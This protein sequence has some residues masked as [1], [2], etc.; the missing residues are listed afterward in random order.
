MEIEKT[1]N[2]VSDNPIQKLPFFSLR[3][4]MIL[5]FGLLFFVSFASFELLTLFGIPF[6]KYEGE[7]ER[8][9]SDVFR[10]LNLVADLKKELIEKW[11]KERIQDSA[12]F[13]ERMTIR[14]AVTELLDKIGEFQA[15]G[16]KGRELWARARQEDIY[17]SL[18]RELK[19]ISKHQF[20]YKKIEIADAGT[21]LVIASTSNA[22]L[23][24]DIFRKYSFSEK[25]A[26]VDAFAINTEK[27][28][29]SGE[30]HLLVSH[31]I[32]DLKTYNDHDDKVVAILVM[33]VDTEGIIKPILYAGGGLGKTGEALLVDQEAR[34]LTSLKHNLSDG[35]KAVPLEYR[36]KAKPSLM[37]AN[38]E[39]GITR[40]KD[41]RGVPVLAAYRYIPITSELGWGMVVKRDR[42]EVFAPITQK[43]FF[44]ILSGLICVFITIVLA[45]WVSSNLANPIHILSRKAEQVASGDFSVRAEGGSYKEVHILVSTF[46]S[47][48]KRIGDW[49][50]ELDEEVKNRT[51]ELK[52]TNKKLTNA[53]EVQKLGE[54]EL[55]RVNIVLQDK[56]KELEQIIY[57]AS[58]DLRSPLVNIHGFTKEIAKTLDDVN[59]IISHEDVSPS[60]QKK[61]RPFLEEDIPEAFDFITAGTSK[62]D[63]LISGLLEVSRLGRVSMDIAP[64]DMNKLIKTIEKS[65]EYQVRKV[66]AILEIEELPPCR[67]HETQ[68]NQVFSNLLDNALKYRIPKRKPIIKISGKRETGQAV[69]CVEDNGIGISGDYQGKIF[70]M[71]H[72]LN[73]YDFVGEGLGLA[74]VSKIVIRHEGKV[75]V[76]SAQDKGS[77]FFISLPV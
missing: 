26:L 11:I 38:G 24:K 17:K 56:N 43:V 42:E 60:L 18:I 32:M 62:M 29:K 63:A 54:K 69:Y 34:I 7:L 12:I 57:V 2:L 20:F 39:E 13:S 66:G 15:S 67:G 8:L 4:K 10:N 36:I 72:R 77:R 16:V 44:S 45:S 22:D 58:H 21:G 74:I 41:Y 3:A 33:H 65:F 31:P 64:L 61:L 48:V 40:S 6:T 27:I 76:E 70:E 23:G 68:I 5:Y 49:H 35:T 30:F 55:E 51:A 37:A 53:I 73:P 50:K 14:A 28:P 47:M 59:S 1:K 9:Q 52:L 25:K 46:N 71:F 75:W 19:L